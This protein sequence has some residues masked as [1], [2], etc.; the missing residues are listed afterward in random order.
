[1]DVI[2]FYLKRFG[3]EN[4]HIV[5]LVGM[6]IARSVGALTVMKAG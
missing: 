4:E 5:K 1:M 6:K 2:A 3:A